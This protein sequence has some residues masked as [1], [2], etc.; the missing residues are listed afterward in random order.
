MSENFQSEH[1]LSKLQEA[2]LIIFKEFIRICEANSLKYYIWGGSFLGAVR[3]KGFIPW[4]DDIDVAMPRKDFEKFIEI[5]SEQLPDDMYLSTYKRGAEHV[6]LVAQIFNKQKD[7]ILNNATKKVRTGAWIDIL[8]IDGAPKPGIKKKIFGMRYMYFRMLNQFAHFDEIVNLNKKRPWYEKMA[9]KFAQITKI[10]KRLNPIK[11]GDKFHKFL[12]SNDYDENNFVATFMGAAKM[13]EIIPKDFIGEGKQYKFE[14]II[15][16]GP[17]KYDE[18]LKHFY[19]DYMTP[20][21]I[22]ARNRHNV[23]LDEEIK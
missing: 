23:T 9:I 21:P 12:K 17:D 22:D 1:K 19:G 2:E 18:Y 14:D 4:D 5:A 10:E 11:I 7:F 13:G 8:V 3:H 16:I 15:V 20:P 6:T